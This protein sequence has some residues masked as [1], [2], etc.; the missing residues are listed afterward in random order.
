MNNA[1]QLVELKLEI[2]SRCPLACIHCSSES[3]PQR[4][5]AVDPSLVQTLA[6]DFV[7]LGGNQVQVSGGEPLEHPELFDILGLLHAGN[8]AVI[9]Y[10]TGIRRDHGIESL[11]AKDVR[12]LRACLRSAIFSIHG[13]SAEV[14]DAFTQTPGSF[15]ATV[16][17]IRLCKSVGIDVALH[18]VP[19]TANYRSLHDT[20][21]LAERL[22]V[23][24]LSLLRFVPHGR[25]LGQ[26]ATLA[27]MRDQ[28]REF[29]EMVND[30]SQSFDIRLRLGSPFSVLQAA[31]VPSC[32]A[33]IDRMLVSP[34]GDAY[35]C[36][37]FKGFPIEDKCRNVYEHGLEN[38]WRNSS[39]LERVR[40]IARALPPSC[41][42]CQHEDTCHGGCP[43]QRA[44]ALGRLDDHHRDPCCLGFA[45]T[46]CGTAERTAEL[47]TTCNA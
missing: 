36:D 13:G 38:V 30:A 33:G 6:Q 16:E 17:S 1:N 31:S 26:G 44:F 28:L 37:A 3:S 46:M 25:G 19:T 9:V 12:K 24:R 18:F 8:I 2:I 41:Q 23:K 21:R 40:Q 47:D 11:T 10:T 5:E 27:L 29:R 4:D 32:L 7:S 35:P 34:S 15:D 22:G 20:V 42:G 45:P 43:A 39:F 14:H